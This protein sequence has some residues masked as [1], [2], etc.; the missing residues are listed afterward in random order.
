MNAMLWCVYS[1]LYMNTQA[2]FHDILPQAC[3]VLTPSDDLTG[4]TQ[5]NLRAWL[6][7]FS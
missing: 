2:E 5:I 1:F 6:Q 7:L 4:K 3:Q